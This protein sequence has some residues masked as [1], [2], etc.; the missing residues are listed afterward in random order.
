MSPK[1]F[2]AFLALKLLA[3]ATKVNYRPTAYLCVLN[4]DESSLDRQY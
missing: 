3:V 1:V 4:T 2:L